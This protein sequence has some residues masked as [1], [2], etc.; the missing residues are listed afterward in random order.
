MD[1]ESKF[2]TKRV[3]D[4]YELPPPEPRTTRTK[5]LNGSGVGR[6]KGIKG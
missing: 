5:E 2:F 3:D 6:K 1:G 4:G